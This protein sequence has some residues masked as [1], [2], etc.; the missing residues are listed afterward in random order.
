MLSPNARR[1][2]HT[3]ESKDSLQIQMLLKGT[4]RSSGNSQPL[5][6]FF[7]LLLCLLC[8]L[9][10]FFFL[11]TFLSSS[12]PVTLFVYYVLVS[13]IMLLGD[14]GGSLSWYFFFNKVKWTDLLHC[15]FL[16][17]Y[18]EKKRITIFSSNSLN[19]IKV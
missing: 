4:H 10:L 8:P 19:Y 12:P 14:I 5:K 17:E 15:C 11:V 18:L 13:S 9:L 7:W 3:L 2:L 16:F 6:Y 1:L